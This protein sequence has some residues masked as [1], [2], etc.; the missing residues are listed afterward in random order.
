MT[1]FLKIGRYYI[2]PERIEFIRHCAGEVI[3]IVM[4]DGIRLYGSM[5]DLKKMEI[6]E[7]P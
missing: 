1:R 7:R 3:E 5:E 4:S 6:I 2:N